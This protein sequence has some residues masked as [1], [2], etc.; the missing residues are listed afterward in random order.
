[1]IKTV[2]L[3]KKFGDIVALS[4]L[5]LSIEPG[6]FV[7]LT[8]PSGSGKTTLLRLVMREY[9]ADSGELI[10]NGEDLKKLKSGKLPHYRRTIGPVFQDFKLLMDRSVFENVSLPLDVRHTKPSDVKAAVKL[11]LEMVNLTN[12]ETLFPSQLSGGEIQRVAIAR[13]IV[14]KPAVI[15][16]DEPT[17]NLDPHTSKNIMKLLR[18]IHEELKTTIVM[19][20]HNVEL[21]NHSSLRVIRLEG[22]KMTRDE[23]KGKYE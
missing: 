13:A 22:G 5:N 6:E 2:N 21:V 23:Q 19:A 12:R 8:G 9:R 20:T 16:A 11:A 15:L 1:M 14:G 17:G 7:F 10:V 18:D 4:E 3:S